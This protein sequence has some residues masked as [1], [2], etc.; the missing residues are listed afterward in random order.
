[1][2]RREF[3]AGVAGAVTL[4][5]AVRA[6]QRGAPVVG[7]LGSAAPEAPI[8]KAMFASLLEG[9][10]QTGYVEG[11]N[12][13]IEY[14]WS[15]ADLDRLPQ[16]AAELVQRRVAAIFAATTDA[17]LAAKAATTTIPIIFAVS[18][19]PVEMGLI[20]SLNRPG[21]NLTGASYL[22][23]E[24][25]AKMVEL[26]HQAAPKA[27]LAAALVNP[28]ITVMRETFTRE[29]E[30]AARILGLEF[31]VFEAASVSEIDSAFATLARLPAPLLLVEP[32]PF[33]TSRLQQIA[34]LAVRD[35]IPAIY[36]I[37]DFPTAGGLMSYGGDLLEAT[38]VAGGYIGQILKG[39]KPADL[40]VQRVT[41]AGL[42][43]NMNAAKALGVIFPASLLAR[44]D[45]VIE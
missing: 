38:R 25:T 43:I 44:A 32:H 33:Y 10:S 42:V 37:R 24:T 34:L 8:V 21:G 9:L 20:A 2:R 7:Y 5:L 15:N 16:L 18:G 1:M 26:L 13:T 36:P 39:D 14:R 6:Q 28:R 45:E 22:S 35:R 11:R 17:T 23:L 30:Q 41:K 4:P 19:D 31:R 12:V 29:A 27:R 40:P 3:I